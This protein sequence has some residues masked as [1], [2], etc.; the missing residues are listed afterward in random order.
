MLFRSVYGPTYTMND[1]NGVASIANLHIGGGDYLVQQ[2]WLNY[3][4]AT[5]SSGGGFCASALPHAPRC[6]MVQGCYDPDNEISGV[7]ITCDPQPFDV[8][9]Q[10]K[11][12][13]GV[14]VDE[15]TVPASSGLLFGSTYATSAYGNA[16]TVDYRACAVLPTGD[17]LCTAD[18]ALVATLPIRKCII[19]VHHCPSGMVN[20]G[21]Y[22]APKAHYCY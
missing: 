16:G 14:Y 13:A 11:N 10:V 21:D 15:Q 17:R 6:R 12:G 8:V 4:P 22:C 18:G 1:A 7:Q 9:F 3:G 2:N 20:C 19:I 5:T